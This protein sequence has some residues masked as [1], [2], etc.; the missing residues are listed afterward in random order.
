MGSGV[1]EFTTFRF[2]S[3]RACLPAEKVHK[4]YIPGH[5]TR[6]LGKW[7]G[8]GK[9]KKKTRQGRKIMDLQKLGS[10]DRAHVFAMLDAFLQ[11]HKA[12][13]YSLRKTVKPGCA[14]LYCLCIR[15]CSDLIVLKLGTMKL[16]HCFI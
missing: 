12:K 14:G 16:R 1:T 2:D 5:L 4:A 10:E 9:E 7:R 15:V 3:R 6:R 11:S 13:K 8:H